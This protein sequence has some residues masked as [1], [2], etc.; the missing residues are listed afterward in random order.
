MPLTSMFG[1]RPCLAR[2]VAN[3]NSPLLGIVGISMIGI[4]IGMNKV[5]TAMRSLGLM[6]PLTRM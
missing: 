2:K 3:M 5:R 6:R 1:L 4:M